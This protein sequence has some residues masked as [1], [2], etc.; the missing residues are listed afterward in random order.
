M[1]EKKAL[2]IN[3]E[4]LD[5]V[6][7]GEGELNCEKYATA[8]DTGDMVFPDMAQVSCPECGGLLDVYNIGNR[9]QGVQMITVCKHCNK[10]VAISM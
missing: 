1:N 8:I 2:E 9:N 10:P 3:D 5:G 7:G 6:N 4:I